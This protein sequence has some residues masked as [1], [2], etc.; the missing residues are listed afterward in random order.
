MIKNIVK[1][2]CELCKMNEGT[3]GFPICKY[4]ELDEEIGYSGVSTKDMNSMY[5]DEC[6]R[7][8]KR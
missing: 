5:T 6:T 1:T 2:D 3:P 4:E 7:Y 8:N